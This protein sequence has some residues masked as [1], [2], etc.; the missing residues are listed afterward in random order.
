MKK[1]ITIILFFL[2]LISITTAQ[3]QI[4]VNIDTSDSRDIQKELH[5]VNQNRFKSLKLQTNLMTE[6]VNDIK[7]T[8]IRFP[9]GTV[10]NYYNW[11]TYYPNWNRFEEEWEAT[12]PVI[13]IKNFYNIHVK[14]LKGDE[15]INYAD[16]LG[17][18]VVVVA[19]VHNSMNFDYMV[20]SLQTLSDLDINI[21]YLEIGNELYFFTQYNGMDNDTY[22]SRAKR[23]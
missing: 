9:G 4:N 1:P 12:S 18:D 15:F 8:H 5:G 6:G 10:S 2:I 7:F 16:S 11:K 3:E 22:L 13:A 20:E 21:K 17:K 19:N 14:S 23:L